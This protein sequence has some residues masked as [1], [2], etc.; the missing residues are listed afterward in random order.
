MPAGHVTTLKVDRERD[1][2]LLRFRDVSRESRHTP[3]SR[4]VVPHSRRNC[5]V[6]SVR[7]NTA[8][9]LAEHASCEGNLSELKAA[10]I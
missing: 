10:A 7:R 8:Y 5:Q 4:D 6:C 9:I 3:L 1:K 2:S